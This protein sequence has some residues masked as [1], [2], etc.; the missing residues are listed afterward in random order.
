MA[1]S[2]PFC[3]MPGAATLPMCARDWICCEAT[4]RH[5]PC[6]RKNCEAQRSPYRISVCLA[7]GLHNWWSCRRKLRSSM[8]L[9]VTV[10]DIYWTLGQYDIWATVDGPDDPSVTA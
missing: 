2:F 6:R 5:E 9:G 7:A 10:K 1:L 3:A 4:R 8:R